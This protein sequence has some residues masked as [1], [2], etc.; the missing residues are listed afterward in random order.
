MNSQTAARPAPAN[1]QGP[2]IRLQGVSK[3]FG[4][5]RAMKEVT[6]DIHHGTVHCLLGENGAGKSTVGKILAGVHTPDEGVVMVDG[7]QVD[8]RTIRQAHDLGIATVFQELSLAP[9]LTV[10]DNITLGTET[11]ML[12]PQQRRRERDRCA[13]LLS[14]L[15]LDL[16]LGARVGDLPTAQQQLVELTKAIHS[17]PRIL[18][19]DEPTAMLGIGD[20]RRLLDIIRRLRAAGT[21][22]IFISHHLEEVIEIGDSVSIMRD[23]A[24][25]ESFALD[26]SIDASQII[27]KVSGKL[28]HLETE[29]LPV[30]T[31]APL[32]SLSGLEGL[33]TEERIDLRPGE[34]IG[35]YG[36]VGCGR[37]EIAEMVV[38]LRRPAPAQSMQF[39]GKPYR[40][41][42]PAAAAR[43]GIGYLP[44]GRASNGIFASMSIRENLTITQLRDHAAG[45]FVRVRDERAA[46]TAQLSRLRT[47]MGSI[48]N[49]ITSLSGGNQ[50][51][52]LLGRWLTDK[53]ALVVME[54]PTAGIDI[55]AKLEIHD[56]IRKRVA[57][58]LAVLLISSDLHETISLCTTVY[59]MFEGRV[60]GRYDRPD[61]A[62]ESQILADVL[63]TSAAA[64]SGTQ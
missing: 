35:L 9:D 52:V 46:A 56:L 10:V 32:L 40:P 34:I 49:S 8:I 64:H 63:G 36:V 54:D 58:G 25:I 37:E 29:P 12:L 41:G 44:T 31:G 55:A 17:H 42:S 60:A 11:R 47:R 18:I 57:E 28:A 30:A 15:G 26:H 59:T 33:G 27:E 16:D 20:R 45:P 22:I 61:P 43:R 5:T 62:R 50:Q 2:I 3:T 53:T 7:R 48:E 14:D 21:T 19:L 38:G 39:A 1:P 51:K 4:A 13:A 24:L 6:L 23:G